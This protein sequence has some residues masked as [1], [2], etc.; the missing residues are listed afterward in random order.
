MLDYW[1]RIEYGVEIAAVLAVV[2]LKYNYA[3]IL[4]QFGCFF[5][6]DFLLQ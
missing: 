2:G 5:M 1:T 3:D 4:S 6:D